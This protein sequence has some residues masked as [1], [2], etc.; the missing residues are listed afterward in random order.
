MGLFGELMWELSE[1]VF[2]LAN[3]GFNGFVWLT[4]VRLERGRLMQ[5]SEI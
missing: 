1:E 2:E 3:M 5:L 4:Y